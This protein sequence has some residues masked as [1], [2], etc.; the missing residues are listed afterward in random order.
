MSMISSRVARKSAVDCNKSESR[1]RANQFLMKPRIYTLQ[2][3]L[4]PRGLA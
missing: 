4:A 1:N 3:K 2:H